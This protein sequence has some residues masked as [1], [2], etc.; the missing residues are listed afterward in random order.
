[1]KS[2]YV[3][4][5]AFMLLWFAGAVHAQGDVPPLVVQI[6]DDIYRLDVNSG[7]M[8]QLTADLDIVLTG[9]GLEMSLDRRYVAFKALSPATLQPGGSVNF[10]VTDIWVLDIETGDLTLVASQPED[11]IY[12]LGGES[13]YLRYSEPT[14]SSDGTRLLWK[15]SDVEN[16]PEYDDLVDKLFVYEPSIDET[17][18]ID[19]APDDP[20]CCTLVNVTDVQW[21]EFG[22]AAVGTVLDGAE[23]ER[24]IQV[25][26]ED[27]E[28]LNEIP[29]PLAAS[30]IL[31]LV[32]KGD[33]EYLYLRRYDVDVLVDPLTGEL[34]P[35]AGVFGKYDRSALDSIS[36]F[37]Y[38]NPNFPGYVSQVSYPD[39]APSSNIDS[40]LISTTLAGNFVAFYIGEGGFSLAT[41]L[42]PGVYVWEEGYIT[43]LTILDD[44]D[45]VRLVWGP[46]GWRVIPFCAPDTPDD[47]LCHEPAQAAG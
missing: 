40:G 19:I 10:S 35:L 37:L 25:Y 22:I 6:G 38:D 4:M 8:E 15:V 2:S 44:F 13:R 12:T 30:E 43:P 46:E 5:C 31:L 33:Q 42:N 24:V 11:A 34:E 28:L 41:T 18:E 20:G 23:G 17:L 1:M 9:R 14:W 47:V 26:S 16:Y 29:D 27:G 39:R 45:V 32:S 21:G 36:V 7:D 3:F